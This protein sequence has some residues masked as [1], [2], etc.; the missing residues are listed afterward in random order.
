M[1]RFLWGNSLRNISLLSKNFP[2]DQKEKWTDTILEPPYTVFSQILIKF[3]LIH[4][5]VEN[6]TRQ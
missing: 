5:H 3:P 6:T 2:T 4:P 1:F